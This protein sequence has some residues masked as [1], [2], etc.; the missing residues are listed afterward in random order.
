MDKFKYY[1]NF[2]LITTNYRIVLFFIDECLIID[3]KLNYLKLVA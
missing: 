1:V 3:I 2:F